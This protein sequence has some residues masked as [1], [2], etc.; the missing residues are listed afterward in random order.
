MAVAKAV[1][2]RTRTYRDITGALNILIVEAAMVIA[3]IL[4]VGVRVFVSSTCHI[5]PADALVISF[6]S[7]KNIAPAVIPADHII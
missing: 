4:G 3:A 7:S 6:V 1:D 2:T 5:F